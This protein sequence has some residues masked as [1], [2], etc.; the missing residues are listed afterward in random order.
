MFLSCSDDAN[1]EQVAIGGA[2][3][4][5]EFKAKS[6]HQPACAVS[7]AR[8][9]RSVAHRRSQGLSVLPAVSA[10]RFRAELRSRRS[11]SSSART[12][13]ANRPCSK[14][15][16]CSPAMTKPAAARA[17][18]RSIIPTRSRRWA[19]SFRRRC[20][21]AGCRRSPMAGSFA[22][23]ASSRSRDI[24]TRPRDDVGAAAGLPLAFARRRLLALLR[25][26]LPAAGHLHL[27]RTGIG[28]VAGA[29]DRIPEADAADGEVHD[30]PGHHG[31]AF[32]DADGLS[33]ARDCCG[34][35][36]TGWSR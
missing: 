35:R 24:S 25:G 30:L 4:G 28:A 13:P 36:N 34:C 2:G 17:I 16:R 7:E 5:H 8:L 26:A 11:P 21:Q 23:R 9:A 19:A 27:R 20:A 31:H 33:R 10:R 12:A 3:R 14:A 29:P 6:H 22:P 15:S 1:L 18:G 32:A